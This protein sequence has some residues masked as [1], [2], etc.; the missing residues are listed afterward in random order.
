MAPPGPSLEPGA[1][2]HGTYRIKDRLASGGMGEVYAAAHERLVGRFAVKVLQPEMARDRQALARFGR[3]AV[4][5]SGL[6]HPHVA[7]VLDFNVTDDGKPYLV[8]ELLE[9]RLLQEVI[10]EGRSMPVVRVASI[11]R[12]IASALAAAHARGVIHR[13]LK[14][15][16]IMLVPVSGDEPFVK[17]FDF[18]ISK[19]KWSKSL[20]Q[21]SAILGTPEYMS[22]EQALGRVEAIDQRTDQFALAA[23]A[24]ALFT[25][26]QAFDGENAVAILYQVVHQQPRPLADYVP[27]PTDEVEAVL[28]RAMA[29]QADDRFESMLDF[30]R[31]LDAAVARVLSDTGKIVIAREEAPSGG[32]P[33]GEMLEFAE[34][35][36]LTLAPVRPRRR[37]RRSRA[38]ML[39]LSL[40][41][42]LAVG[43]TSGLGGWKSAQER[44]TEAWRWAAARVSTALSPQSA[45]APAA[46]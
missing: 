6:Q 15:E 12:Q 18:G 43:G 23:I 29:K 21:E 32:V 16:N 13:D 42:M 38:L 20:T 4:I 39:S 45:A 19:V 8:M 28:T 9:G 40:L 33:T 41:A 24:Y 17:V 27:W 44:V 14:P 2:L 10:D 7:Q 3:E 31:A 30:S 25:G 26:S 35:T 36:Q 22:P 46:R 34:S 5:M 1:L 37:R 11:V